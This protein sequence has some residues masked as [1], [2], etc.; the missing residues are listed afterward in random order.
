MEMI[1]SSG[2][3]F[4]HSVNFLHHGIQAPH[5]AGLRPVHPPCRNSLRPADSPTYIE[6][7]AWL[8][9]GSYSGKAPLHDS[10]RRRRPRGKAA[11]TAQ[12]ITSPA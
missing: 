3:Q 11:D 2:N 12:A 7:S 4:G 1:R 5:H 10:C 6:L 8:R 9:D